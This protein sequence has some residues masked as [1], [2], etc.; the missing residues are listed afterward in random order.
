MDEIKTVAIEDKHYPEALKKIPD[1]PL[2][3]YYRGNLEVL[4]ENCFSIV[5]TRKPSSYGQ[6]S[7]LRV[8]GDLA[9]A[10]FTIVS[11]MAPGIDTFAHQAAVE[12]KKRTIA[13]LGSG[14][15][16]KTIY[17]QQ[18]LELSRKIVEL[19]G[20]LIS[21]LPPKYRG[22]KFTFPKRNR[23]ISG[24]SLGVLVVEAKEKSGSLITAE[25]AVTHRKKLFAIP[26][27]IFSANSKGPN[28]LI[29][30]GAQLVESAKDILDVLQFE[31]AVIKPKEIVAE[32]QEEKLILEAIQAESL[33]IDAIIKTTKLSASA[34]AA[35]LALMEISGKIRNLGSNVYSLNF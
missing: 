5:G 24:L 7:A 18:N 13:V 20:C 10:G 15:D 12:R 2:I 34:V 30:A 31:S 26:G 16:E 25:Y 21:E 27:P 8:A 9:D 33:D 1:A 23:I 35:T 29:K 3:L 4:T 22:T 17:P 11:G 19:G 28:T 32:N 14:L 6:Q